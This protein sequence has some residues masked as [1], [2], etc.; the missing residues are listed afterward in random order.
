MNESIENETAM[1]AFD[2]H[3][4]LTSIKHN[5]PGNLMSAVAR[6][7]CSLNAEELCERARRNTG[8]SDFGDPP[9]EAPLAALAGS[10]EDEA[11]LHPLGRFLMREHLLG[12][13]KTRLRL[14]Q[15]V[16]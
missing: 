14:T 13:L 11:D 3:S 9:V 2:G 7:W 10:L 16:F 6:R 8:L 4:L 12:L 15:T 1:P 5:V